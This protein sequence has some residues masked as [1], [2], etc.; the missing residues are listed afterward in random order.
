MFRN[1]W[2]ESERYIEKAIKL[3]QK[4]GNK[5]DEAEF[6]I[7][8]QVVVNSELGSDKYSSEYLDLASKII[9]EIGDLRKKMEL[10]LGY[11]DLKMKSDLHHEARSFTMMRWK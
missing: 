11:G 3:A 4:T 2:D 9:N 10:K 8:K 6:L 7:A 5:S 1:D